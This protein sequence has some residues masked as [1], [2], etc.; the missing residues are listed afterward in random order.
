MELQLSSTISIREIVNYAIGL[1]GIPY[2]W[3]RDGDP[4]MA[5]NQFWASNEHAPDPLEIHRSD[6][7]TIVCTGLINLMR[8]FAGLK[9]P[10]LEGEVGTLGLRFPGTTGIW[11]E[12]L[13]ARNRLEEFEPQKRYPQGTLLLRNFAN[14]EDDQGHVAV[15]FTD[16]TNCCM[17]EYIIHSFANLG[18][19]ESIGCSPRE[20]GGVGLTQLLHSH[21]WYITSEERMEM[22]KRGEYIEGGYYTHVCLPENWLLMN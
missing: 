11:F 7:K 4:I 17:N 5:D 1:I 10:G 3:H 21:Y 20:I 9:I 19:E 6:N 18:Y 13:K 2:K 15:L 14:V 22:M 12:Y 16:S 8:R